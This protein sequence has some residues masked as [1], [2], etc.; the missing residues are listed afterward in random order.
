[1]LYGLMGWESYGKLKLK[2]MDRNNW[3]SSMPRTL[4][5][6]WVQGSAEN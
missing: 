4:L 5:E 3:R 2:A 1:M 6:G